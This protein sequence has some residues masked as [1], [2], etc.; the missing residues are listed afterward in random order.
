MK[1]TDILTESV[2][3]NTSGAGATPYNADVDY[4]GM[5][6]QMSPS[7]FLQLALPLDQPTSADG[8]TQ[9]LQN[10]GKIA[11][12]MLFVTIPEEWEHG[13]FS[14]PAQI[15][16]H[17][18]RNRMI[19]YRRIYGNIPVEVHFILNKGLRA[20]DLTPEWVAALK[21]TL[22]SQ[23]GRLVHGPIFN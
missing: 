10:G 11:S 22:I 19:A 21:K 5:R 17:E 12:P 3:D 6:T 13:D 18:G 7:M 2:I 4:F 9:H 20:R 23:S 1:V 8:L 14:S 16:G 15:K